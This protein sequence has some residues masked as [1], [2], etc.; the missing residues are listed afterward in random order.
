MKTNYRSKPASVAGI[1][2]LVMAFLLIPAHSL[3]AQA[4]E[5]Q[6]PAPATPEVQ[7]LKER[8]M[9]LE[10]TVEQLKAQ[11]QSDLALKQDTLVL[12]DVERTELNGLLA[13][14]TPSDAC[15]RLLA[16]RTASW[17]ILR[18]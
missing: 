2:L 11:L 18:R 5:P 13:K 10:Q 7:Q 3:L 14:P 1:T 8:L 4:Q 6:K 17:S 12:T 15:R 16:I 9:Q